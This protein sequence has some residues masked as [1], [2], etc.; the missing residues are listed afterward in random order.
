GP[1]HPSVAHAAA[2]RLS[3][4]MDVWRPC[5]PVEAA[6]AR[7]A[8]IER[9]D[10]PTSLLFTRQN[11][12]FQKRDAHTVSSIR[13]G[14]YVPAGSQEPKVVRVTTG[15]AVRGGVGQNREVAG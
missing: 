9:K 13:R 15:S 2:L 4:G 3:P 5:D 1:T 10:G 8:A 11:V 6:L 14:A 12:P 7:I